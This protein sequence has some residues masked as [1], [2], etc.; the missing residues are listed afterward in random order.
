MTATPVHYLAAHEAA[1]LLARR[2]VSSVEITRAVLERVQAANDS[3]NAFLTITEDEA[4]AQARAA[5]ERIAPGE[6]P[7]FGPTRNPW[8]RDRVPGG[9]SSGSAAAV[10]AGLAYY[11][12]GSDTGGSIRQPASLSGVVGFKPTYGRGS[13]FRLVAFG[14]SLD[15]S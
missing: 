9:S 14:S 11:A 4:L 8:A 2:E 3:L 10:A 15:H 7:A 13:P 5:D 1:D 6:T 12:L